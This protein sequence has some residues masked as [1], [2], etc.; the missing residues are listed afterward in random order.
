MTLCKT[1]ENLPL[2]TNVA[3]SCKKCGGNTAYFAYKLCSD[4][5]EAVDQCE[6]CEAPMKGGPSSTS[7]GPTAFRIVV[8]DNDDG[9]LK[10]G[11]HPGDEIVVQLEEDQYGQT[12]WGHKKT[13]SYGSIFRLKANNGFTPYPGQYQKGTRE[14]IFEIT[15]IGTEDLECEEMVRTYSY[16]SYYGGGYS[17]PS[18][19]PAPNGKQW[20]VTVQS[21]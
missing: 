18:T 8:T 11:M 2:P 6:R 1:C 19:S 16:Y 7:S 3:G 20:K 12:E 15:G 21:S 13:K 17:S 5:A 14:L 4:C 9:A 10:N